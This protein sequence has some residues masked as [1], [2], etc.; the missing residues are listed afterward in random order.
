[1]S[2]TI[3]ALPKTLEE[4]QKMKEF[5]LSKAENTCLLFL[6]AL[7]LFVQN[8]AEGIAALNLLKG[9]VALNPYDISFLNDRLYDKKYLPL[10]YFNGA[11]PSNNYT[12]DIPYTLEVSEHIAA[13]PGYCYRKLKTSGADSLRPL[14]LRTKDGKWYIYEYSSILTGIRL[15]QK[16]DPW[17]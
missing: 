14:K 17:A 4:F 1:M 8:K 3:A 13:E 11:L 5:D 9:P 15:P 6:C 7:N 16:E 10:A 2:I 12:P